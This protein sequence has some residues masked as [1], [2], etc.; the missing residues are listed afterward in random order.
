MEVP[1]IILAAVSAVAGPGASVW[2]A[3]ITAGKSIEEH[4]K[5]LRL[6]E[7]TEP[8]ALAK[9]R[10]DL[11]ALAKSVDALAADLATLRRAH[12]DRAR[13]DDERRARVGDAA[14]AREKEQNDVITAL[15]VEIARLSE[16]L[17]ERTSALSQRME[18]MPRGR[19]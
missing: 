13:A 2:V 7:T 3:R 10:E 1:S 12:E 5:R 9:L 14:R 16:R 11:T 17:H 4:D 15:R 8:E 6:L 18:E 19:R